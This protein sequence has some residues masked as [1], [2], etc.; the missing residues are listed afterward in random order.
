MLLYAFNPTRISSLIYSTAAILILFPLTF[1]FAQTPFYQGKTITM[2]ASRAPGGTG[3]LR[4]KTLLPFLRKHIP[5]N[6]TIVMEYY[7]WRRW[8]QSGQSHV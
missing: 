8:A 1:A 4:D 3:D 5:G 2:I 7:G 6:P